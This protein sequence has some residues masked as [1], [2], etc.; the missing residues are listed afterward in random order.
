MKAD[1]RPAP[2]EED[3]ETV[4]TARLATTSPDGCAGE[5]TLAGES[6][7]RDDEGDEGVDGD[8]DSVVGDGTDGEESNA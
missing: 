1:R 5:K 7:E 6:G 3:G 2:N 8:G 4:T